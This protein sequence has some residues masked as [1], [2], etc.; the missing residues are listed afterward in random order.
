MLHCLASVAAL[1]L[2]SVDLV[3]GVEVCAQAD[4]AGAHLGNDRADRSVYSYMGCEKPFPRPDPEPEELSAMFGRFLT[5]LPF[6]S[7]CLTDGRF[8]R[9]HK[10]S[11]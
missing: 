4:L 11:R 9:C 6:V 5:S 7:H 2:V 3:D 8:R 1:A 10:G